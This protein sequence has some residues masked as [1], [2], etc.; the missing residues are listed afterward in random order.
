MGCVVACQ[1][2]NVLKINPSLIKNGKISKLTLN[3]RIELKSL[4][5]SKIKPKHLKGSSSLRENMN[6]I[7]FGNVFTYFI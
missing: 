4:N 1:N 2:F 5:S 7:I 6:A 3:K